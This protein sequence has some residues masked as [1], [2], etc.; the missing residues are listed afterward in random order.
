MIGIVT[1][2]LLLTA[3]L[4]VP[5]PAFAGQTGQAERRAEDAAAAAK[6]DKN[7]TETLR[8]NRPAVHDRRA[9][10]GYEDALERAEWRLEKAEH[11]AGNAAREA[12]RAVH[13][14]EKGDRERKVQQRRAGRRER[15]QRQADELTRRP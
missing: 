2:S 3:I 7:A 8:A 9:L 4:T 11:K 6:R 5:G 1:G 14:A 12:K 13:R 15:L 10:P